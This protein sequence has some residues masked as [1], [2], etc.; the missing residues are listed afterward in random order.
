MVVWGFGLGNKKRPLIG[1][2]EGA[3][4]EKMRKGRFD[5]SYCG[6]NSTPLI[7]TLSCAIPPAFF[8]DTDE[9]SRSSGFCW[10]QNKEHKLWCNTAISKK[11]LVGYVNNVVAY[12]V[13]H[14]SLY[15]LGWRTTSPSILKQVSPICQ[16]AE[17][18]ACRHLE[19]RRE[20]VDPALHCRIV[21]EGVA[22]KVTELRGVSF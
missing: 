4:W 17:S 19:T 20:C 22:V 3:W 16:K 6:I 13:L 15:V 9:I 1:L 8:E 18:H 10:W 14:D 7:R 11:E 12:V 5:K 2:K 21:I